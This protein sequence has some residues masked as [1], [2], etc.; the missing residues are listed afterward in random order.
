MSWHYESKYE[1][2]NMKKKI[3]MVCNAHL[4]PVWLWHWED[5]VTE[6]FATYRIA[7]DFAEKHKSFIFNHNESL[8]YAFIQKHEPELH[9]RIKKLVKAGRWSIAGGAYLQPDVNCTSGESHIRQYLLGLNF[10]KKEFNARPRTAYNFDPFGHGE[11]F[12]QVLKSCGMKSYIFC[13]PG[14]GDYKLP[15]GAFN[16]KDRSGAEIVTRRSDDHY[17]TRNN[18]D[19]KM[20][21]WIEHYKD[22]EE[23]MILWGIGN[24]GGGP[25]R[26]DYAQMQAYIKAHPEYDIIEST[27]DAF[28]KHYWKKQ[29]KLPVIEGEI[30]NSF[31][32][33]FTSMSRV[34]R[35]HR[36]AESLMTTAERLAALAWWFDNT[37]YPQESLTAAWKDILFCE[38]HDILPGTCVPSAETDS[39]NM[40]GHCNELLRRTRFET[41]VQ[42]LRGEK[43]PAGSEVPVFITNPHGFELNTVVEFEFNVGHLYHIANPDISLLKNGKAQPFQRIAA[44]HNLETDWRIRL[45]VPVSLKP[46]EVLRLDAH[47]KT[48]KKPNTY[49]LPKTTEKS[50]TI[51]TKKLTIK[52]SK[53]SGL[54]ERVVRKGERESI[55][56]KNSFR[57]VVFKDHDHSWTTADTD[58]LD[59]PGCWATAPR[60]K[61]I[62]AAF[63]RASKEEMQALSPLAC[64]TWADKSQN[65]AEPVRIIED[66]DI[67]TIVETAFVLEKSAIIRHYV[68]D[69]VH[70]TLDIRDRIFYQHKDYMLK[71][72][73]P[74][75]FD[76]SKS[77]S[78]TIYSALER[79]STNDFTEQTNQ[80]WVAVSGKNNAVSIANT[81]SFAHNLK[82]NSL[83]LNVMRSPAYSSFGLAVDRRFTDKR[84]RPRQD[85]GEHEVAYKIRFDKRFNEMKA[86]HDAAALNASAWYQVYFPGKDAKKRS[87]IMKAGSPIQ[88]SAK[89]IEIVAVKKAENKNALVI[90]LLEHAGKETVCKLK[91]AG[92]AKQATI[93]F[94]PYQLKTIEVSRKGKII[95]FKETNSVEGL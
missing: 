41:I 5:G 18:L 60:W 72:E 52:I 31:P 74:L 68:I 40:M 36:E 15:K 3:H 58:K 70:D 44:E 28:F 89:N 56:K 49:P 2:N 17:L 84:F 71:L 6:A 7:A 39:L 88:L 38:F 86:C 53:N 63:K 73:L 65:S 27:P 34:K 4:D 42:V 77:I 13:R 69:K 62:T 91:L 8:L 23:T 90:R 32:G 47:Y 50:L 46:F 25:S 45:A 95:H 75:N 80:R 57:P 19:Q 29:S 21:S 61:K 82:G 22:E 66:G 1:M 78:E 67:Y 35:A 16:W 43:V 55:V 76:V 20:N 51:K 14:V 92:N 54:V 85:Q 81:G 26:I 83:F 30:Q 9:E 64:D 24:H 93:N 37:P 33:C 48:G 59:A 12:Q 94:T 79:E 87:G 10:F 11:G